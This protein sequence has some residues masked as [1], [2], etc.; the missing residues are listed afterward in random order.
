MK[1]VKVLGTGCKKCNQVLEIIEQTIVTQ[2]LDATVIK[3][4]D[5]ATIMQYKVISTP[6]IVVE[7]Q[8]VSTGAIPTSEQIINWLAN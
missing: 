3:V 8:V 5:L 2:N 4:S 6:A 7:E 1:S